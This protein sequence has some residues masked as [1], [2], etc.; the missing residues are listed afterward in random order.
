M[1]PGVGPAEQPLEMT[2]Q[3]EATLVWMH[4]EPGHMGRA[5]ELKLANQWA[6]ASLTSLKYRVQREHAGTRVASNWP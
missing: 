6:S 4:D 5:Y 3:F 1:V 2:D